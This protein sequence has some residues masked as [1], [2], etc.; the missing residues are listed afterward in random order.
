MSTT[1]VRMSVPVATAAEDVWDAVTD[2][3]R[4]GEWMLGT[5]VHVASGDGRSPGS[6]LEAFTSVA[7]LGFL[8]VMEITVWDPPL[9]CEVRHDGRLLRGTGG[10]RVVRNTPESATLMWWERLDLPLG[11]FG[12]IAWSFVRPVF[13]WG[14]RRSLTA[15]QSFCTRYPDMPGGRDGD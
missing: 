3:S 8:D 11:R 14:L 15:F 6:R 1:E 4:Q 7:G 9:R 2:W 12:A 13:T 10:F 5:E